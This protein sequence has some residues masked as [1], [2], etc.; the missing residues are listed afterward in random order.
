MKQRPV[1]ERQEKIIKRVQKKLSK[2]QWLLVF[3]NIQDT[4]VIE[5]YLAA[6]HKMCGRGRLVMIS[7]QF[8]PGEKFLNSNV[9]TVGHLSNTEKE[10]FLSQLFYN[11]EI[12]DLTDYQQA[13]LLTFSRELGNQTVSS[14]QRLPYDIRCNIAHFLIQD[15]QYEVAKGIYNNILSSFQ[16]ENRQSEVFA[17]IKANLANA[18]R[19]TQDCDEAMRQIQNSLEIYRDNARGRVD[20][21]VNRLLTLFFT[22]HPIKNENML[23]SGYE[24]VKRTETAS[25]PRERALS[26]LDLD[27]LKACI[28][29]AAIYRDH[30][31]FEKSRIMLEEI[32]S[33]LKD[34]SSQGSAA[35]LAL[36]KRQLGNT[37]RRL[38]KH[39]ESLALLEESGRYYSTVYSQNHFQVALTNIYLGTTH[40]VRGDCQKSIKFLQKAFDHY[41]QKYGSS[42]FEYAWVA[43]CLGYAYKDAGCPEEA[44]AFLKEALSIYQNTKEAHH[45]MTGWCHILLG[46]AER[47][48][49]KFV[50]AE[51]HLDK[52][53]GI[54]RLHVNN[55]SRMIWAQLHQGRLVRDKL[56]L[57]KVPH[58][59]EAHLRKIHEIVVNTEHN[60]NESNTIDAVCR[61]Q[62]LAQNYIVL[63]KLDRAE[64]YFHKA[65][66]LK[67]FSY[68]TYEGLAD[69]YT[70]RADAETRS[71]E[72]SYR[73]RRRAMSF[74]TR[75]LDDA[76]Q[77][78]P[79]RSDHLVRLHRKIMWCNLLFIKPS[80]LIP[81]LKT[82]GLHQKR[83]T[84]KL[85][86]SRP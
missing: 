57:T 70:Q 54:Y 67:S 2:Q 34:S 53:T 4:G 59:Q 1:S 15:G 81:F 62:E 27:I 86:E 58:E 77:N 47:A 56:S 40:H 7:K 6:A 8:H 29:L 16:Q 31:E 51:Q 32:V 50:R 79:C 23:L 72:K 44:Q 19:E 78:L 65:L 85:Q 82:R 30:G 80:Y 21:T 83:K 55:K 75:A 26:P 14:I 17:F 28:F 84:A 52:G 13:A 35:L 48:L 33:L 66:T 12:D 76:R 43:T 49:R 39:D 63:G 9:V 24:E 11:K 20:S 46:D 64:H 38:G 37:Y 3:D 5:Q 60:N 71:S 41:K 18:Y 73:L 68:L 69:L 61:Y 42:H 10:S 74:F 45:P 22:I 36:A 25:L